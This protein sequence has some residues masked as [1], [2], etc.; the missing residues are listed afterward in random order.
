MTRPAV[1]F[2]CQHL[3]G[4]GHIS[5][6]LAICRAL[7]DHFDVVFVQGGPDIGRTIDAPGFTHVFLPPLLMREHDSSLYDPEGKRSVDALWKARGDALAPLM[8][9][10]Y[11]AVVVELYPFGRNK[12]K[13]EILGLIAAARAK[14]PSTQ[15]YC[16]NRDI[17]VQKFDQTAREAKIVRILK[18]HFDH[19]L[20]HSD[21]ALIAMEDTFAAT[22]EIAEMIRYT[23]YVADGTTP[24]SAERTGILVSLGGG[25]VGDEL[26]LAC[27]AVAD[28]FPDHG[29]HLL[30]GPYT[31]EAA[32]TRFVDIAAASRNITIG[33]F[34]EDFRGDLSRAALSVSLA[35]Y[36]TLMDILAAET[37]AL[38]YPYMANR[39][40]NMR[41]SALAD[42]GLVGVIYEDDLAPDR[43]EALIRARL[44]APRPSGRIDLSGASRSA[45]IIADHVAQAST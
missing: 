30:T 6:S 32:R 13:P 29:M 20:V 15:V 37:P 33:G 35:G 23:G 18:D 34:S 27:L 43:L 4:V 38:V 2:Y 11:A 1:L 8:T 5:R 41:A 24:P 16:S 36:N 22:P 26:A 3:L 10:A 25:A 9:R 31:T 39:E 21:P 40:Q 12:F 14:N 28:R 7:L 42:R 45:E 44:A 17:M 19:V